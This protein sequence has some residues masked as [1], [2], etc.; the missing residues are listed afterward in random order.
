[1]GNCSE[2]PYILKV[3]TSDDV[4]SGTIWSCMADLRVWLSG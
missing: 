4:G 1:M 3:G 2:T